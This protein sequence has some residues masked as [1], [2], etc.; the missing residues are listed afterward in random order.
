MNK[1][2][3]SSMTDNWATPEDIFQELDREFHFT[4]DPCADA[5]NH[6]CEKY[7]DKSIDG[8]SQNWGG[9]RY[10]AILRMAESFL[11]GSRN[12]SGKGI[13]ITHLLLC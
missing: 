7:F 1:V 9:T 4:L 10:F 2:F 11:S 6:K 8:L 13:R 12:L 3:F 5:S